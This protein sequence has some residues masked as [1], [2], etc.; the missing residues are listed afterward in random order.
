VT[1]R[2]HYHYATKPTQL[3]TQA[4]L[5]S[6]TTIRRHQSTNKWLGWWQRTNILHRTPYLLN[7]YVEKQQSNFK[8]NSNKRRVQ[9][10]HQNFN[11]LTVLLLH[12]ITY[13]L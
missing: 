9:I 12:N 6:T 3:K 2:T 5:L 7:N 10:W 13:A 1:S 11:S 4:K 8:S